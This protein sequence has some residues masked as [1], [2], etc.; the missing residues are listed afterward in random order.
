VLEALRA[1][2]VVRGGD[3]TSLEWVLTSPEAFGLVT[4]TPGQRATCRVIDGLPL[5]DLATDPN[6]ISI[7][8][9]AE[10]VAWW[11]EN[12]HQALEYCEVAGIRTAKSL[13]IAALAV[14]ASQRCDVSRLGP[15]EIPRFS[16]V[17]VDMDKAKVVLEHLVG[18]LQE[19]ELLRGLML[20][21]PKSDSV[22]LR[23]P[24]GRPVEVKIVAGA[25]A[26]STLVSRWSA[27]AAFDEGTRMVGAEDGVVNLDDARK[28][29]IGRML[30]GAQ[31][32][33]MGSAWAPFGPVHDMVKACWGKPKRDM[34]VARAKAWQMNPV[35]WTPEAC[36]ALKRQ[37]PIAYETDVESNFADPES[38]MFAETPLALAT[39]AEP[40]E[41]PPNEL[42]S[43]SAAMDPA[44]SGGNAWTLV[45]ATCPR[46]KSSVTEPV[47]VTAVALTR[48]WV[49]QAPDVVLR[50]TAEA[51]KPYGVTTVWTD[52]WSADA[53]RVIARQFGLQLV[54]REL[55]QKA[56][57]QLYDGLRLRI[58]TGSF[59][60]SPD[61]RVSDDLKRVRKK[62]T[63]DG[64]KIV[65]PVTADGRHCDFAPAL[66]L[67]TANPI[68][69]PKQ[70]ALVPGTAM[71]QKAQQDSFLEAAI[72][73][74]AAAARKKPKPRNL[75]DY[76]R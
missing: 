15:G 31:V 11:E 69:P 28:A 19:S 10:A 73:K 3:L 5:G 60:L 63:Q 52:Q 53:L 33:Y 64:Y 75:R 30:P 23:H 8:G 76:L 72:A 39:R 57:F 37:D 58:E 25:R 12:H 4:A 68:E 71:W 27:G 44:G 70:P 24:S 43:F 46:V 2:R 38:S 65:L 22:L 36:E 29:V 55:Y 51:L 20:D 21:E 67:A 48:E 1:K 40:L 56:K 6:V 59:E 54:V 49:G 35:H 18:R 9:G 74:R 45:L 47:P 32:V 14:R 62:V 13:K 50:E 7:M 41:L 34:V 26:G 61:A 66:V 16:I 17:S 42:W